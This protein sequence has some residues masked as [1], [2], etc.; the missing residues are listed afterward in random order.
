MKKICMIQQSICSKKVSF[1]R[2]LALEVTTAW[3]VTQDPPPL[4]HYR[5]PLLPLFLFLQGSSQWTASTLNPSMGLFL[6]R[7]LFFNLCCL[8]L[9]CTFKVACGPANMSHTRTGLSSETLHSVVASDDSP[10]DS[11]LIILLISLMSCLKRKNNDFLAFWLNCRIKPCTDEIVFIVYYI[12]PLFLLI[13]KKKTFSFCNG[14][15]IHV[16]RDALGRE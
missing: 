10:R 5:H 1:S 9:L 12:W 2:G 4:P 14:I 6:I 3:A 8:A 11:F 15:C 7:W 13:K 16:V